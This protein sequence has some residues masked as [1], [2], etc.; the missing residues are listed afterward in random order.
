MR[1]VEKMSGH[2]SFPQ[3]IDYGISI[4]VTKQESPCLRLFQ[5]TPAA[6]SILVQRLLVGVSEVRNQN[7]RISQDIDDTVK[8]D[9]A[10]RVT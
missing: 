2:S 1:L 8:I 10:L 7:E 4:W 6:H 3:Q 9:V 5:A